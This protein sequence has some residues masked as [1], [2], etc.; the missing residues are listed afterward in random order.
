MNQF[1]KIGTFCEKCRQVMCVCASKP[2][3]TET[4]V[5]KP[6][7]REDAIKLIEEVYNEWDMNMDEATNTR[8]DLFHAIVDALIEAGHIQPY[9]QL[10]NKHMKT[11]QEFAKEVSPDDKAGV[12]CELEKKHLLIHVYEW[13]TR[14]AKIYHSEHL[15]ASEVRKPINREEDAIKVVEKVYNH[16]HDGCTDG[17]KPDIAA[18]HLTNPE[19]K[20]NVSTIK[21]SDKKCGTSLGGDYYEC[22]TCRKNKENII[23]MDDN[24]NFCPNCGSKINWI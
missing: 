17:Y 13:M 14:Y 10:I 8:Q 2:E 18:G 11:P 12:R 7:N 23:P 16:W 5:R 22:P 20:T 21:K 1:D 19:C 3:L 6:I 4:P 24:F 9:H 15:P